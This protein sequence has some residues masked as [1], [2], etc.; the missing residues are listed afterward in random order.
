MEIQN[1]LYSN[2]HLANLIGHQLLTVDFTDQFT[3][4]MGKY[5]KFLRGYVSSTYGIKHK[6]IFQS[7]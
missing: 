2:V 7:E 3:N 6:I 4:Q 5:K 1:L